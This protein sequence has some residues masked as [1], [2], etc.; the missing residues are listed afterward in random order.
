MRHYPDDTPGA[1]AR[2]HDIVLS[3]EDIIMK[4]SLSVITKVMILDDIGQS[5][6]GGVNGNVLVN[7]KHTVGIWSAIRKCVTAFTRCHITRNRNVIICAINSY[8]LT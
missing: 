6:D 4:Q 5:H 8:H 3:G 2:A 1:A 7:H